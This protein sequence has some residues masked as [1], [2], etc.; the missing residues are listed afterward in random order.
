MVVAD[1]GTMITEAAVLGIPG[2]L[3]LSNAKQFG[4][5]LELE[6]KYGLIY[7][8]SEPEKAIHKAVE[9]IQ[10]PGLKE[11]WDIKKQKLLADKIDVTQFMVD[12]VENYKC[13]H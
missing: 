13:T 7:S 9:L 6:Q 10:Q 3:C 4:N 12:Y 8:F 11:Q 2:I 5:F 1:T